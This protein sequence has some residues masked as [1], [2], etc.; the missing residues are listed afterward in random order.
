MTYAYKFNIFKI[1]QSGPA[2]YKGLRVLVFCIVCVM[3]K[4]FSASHSNV[5]T[6]QW[7]D[8]VQDARKIDTTVV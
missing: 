5:L 7:D 1:L 8:K 4:Y 6:K 3:Q 2:S